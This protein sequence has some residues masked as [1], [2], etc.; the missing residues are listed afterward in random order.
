MSYDHIYIYIYIYMGHIGHGYMSRSM[1][2]RV[3]SSLPNAT[4]MRQ[5]IRS[6]LVQIMACRLFSAKPL[7]EPMLSY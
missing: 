5:R 2:F 4:Y 7:P 6:A 3:N 1:T